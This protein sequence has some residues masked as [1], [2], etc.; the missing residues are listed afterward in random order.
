[1]TTNPWESAFNITTNTSRLNSPMYFDGLLGDKKYDKYSEPESGGMSLY[2]VNTEFLTI[3]K[4]KLITSDKTVTVTKTYA[5]TRYITFFNWLKTIKAY[6]NNDD[7]KITTY[8]I[9]NSIRTTNPDL[10]RKINII[11]DELSLSTT[12]SMSSGRRR[13]SRKYKKSKRVLRRK[14]RSTRRR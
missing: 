11:F 9:M 7:P 12:R 2:T 10:F 13:H 4:S 1:M 14:S 3:S 5:S 8:H 6:T